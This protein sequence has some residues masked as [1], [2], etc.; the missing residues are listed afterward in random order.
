MPVDCQFDG[1]VLSAALPGAEMRHV[2][3]GGPRAIGV[4]AQVSPPKGRMEKR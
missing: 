4:H 3:E 2:Q 1:A